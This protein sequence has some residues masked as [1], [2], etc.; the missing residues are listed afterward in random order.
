MSNNYKRAL[1]KISINEDMKK[2]ILHNVLSANLQIKNTNSQIKNHKVLT[3]NI[4]IIAVSFFTLALSL[5]VVNNNL[6]LFKHNRHSLKQKYVHNTNKNSQNRQSGKS[7]NNYKRY[8]IENKNSQSYDMS[9]RQKDANKYVSDNKNYK[10]SDPLKYK[11]NSI[12]DNK[13]DDNSN[14]NNRVNNNNKNVKANKEENNNKENDKQG[15]FPSVACGNQIKE[16]KTLEEAEREVNLNINYIKEIPDGFDLNKIY[17][18]EDNMIEVEYINGKDTINFRAG[19]DIGNTGDVSNTSGVENVC[20]INKISV[21][22]EES[23]N[24]IV[25]SATW[26]NGELSYSISF[27]NGIDEKIVISMI[28]SSL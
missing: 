22:L 4:L 15:K 23:K 3:R 1:D 20:K 27:K 28:K 19:K 12:S 13:S 18:I 5:N 16:Y 8:S 26:K 25:N 24:K 21:N 2:R 9:K 17:V 10:K 11:E 6:K 14:I 7:Y